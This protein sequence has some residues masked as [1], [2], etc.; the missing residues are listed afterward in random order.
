[1]KFRI[2]DT[3]TGR[4]SKLTNDE[5]KAVKQTAFDLQINPANLGMSFHK[6]GEA[7]DKHNAF[8]VELGLKPLP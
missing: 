6:L 3:F 2:A 4:L 7:K 1:M 5:H 8:L